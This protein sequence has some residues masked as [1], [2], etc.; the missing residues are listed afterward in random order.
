LAG[1]RAVRAFSAV[2]E[3]FVAVLAANQP[4]ET[5]DFASLLKL[6]TAKTAAARHGL[7]QSTRYSACWLS[8]SMKAELIEASQPAGEQ[9]PSKKSFQVSPLPLCRFSFP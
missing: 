7:Q 5:Q 6:T 4:V 1:S 3:G 8:L 9:A 2:F